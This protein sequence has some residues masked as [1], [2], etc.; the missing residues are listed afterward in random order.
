MP[1]ATVGVATLGKNVCFHKYNVV[2][3]LIKSMVVIFVIVKATCS[4]PLPIDVKLL[5]LTKKY[6]TC[7]FDFEMKNFC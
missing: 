2:R 3:T 5:E 4:K 6:V 7:R 1:V